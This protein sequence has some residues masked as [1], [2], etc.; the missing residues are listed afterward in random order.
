[1]T[2]SPF[3]FPSSRSLRAE[4]MRGEGLS[5]LLECSAWILDSVLMVFVTCVARAW[6]YDMV[7]LSVTL[8]WL[9]DLWSL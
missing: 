8:D 6:W 4:G 5:S 7:R 3:P 2:S 9:S 1:M